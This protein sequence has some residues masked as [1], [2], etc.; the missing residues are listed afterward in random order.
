MQNKSSE[1]L[2]LREILDSMAQGDSHFS[3][4]G[5]ASP[6]YN[7]TFNTTNPWQS[8]PTP[9]DHVTNNV[10]SQNDLMLRER[11]SLFAQDLFTRGTFAHGVGTF[12]LIFLLFVCTLWITKEYVLPTLTL[13]FAELLC[14][15]MPIIIMLFVMC[16][17]VGSIFRR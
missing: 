2:A 8:S 14:A 12:V 13:M 7:A 4:P 17:L 9:F 5:N 6:L 15:L 11:F 10:P 3:A 1:E 16:L